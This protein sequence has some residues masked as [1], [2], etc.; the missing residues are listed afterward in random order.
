MKKVG[1][2]FG[3]RSGEHEVSLVSASAIAHNFNREEFEV[4]P[5]FISR[6]GRWYGPVALEDIKTASAEQYAGKEA[7]S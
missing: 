7:L 1:L 5:L 4:I 6:E 2:L 3:G